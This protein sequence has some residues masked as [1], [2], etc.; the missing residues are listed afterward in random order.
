M[1]NVHRRNEAI[2]K[3][4]TAAILD[5]YQRRKDKTVSLR[6]ITQEKT[7]GEIADIDRLVDTFGI[8][9]FRG[10]ERLNQDEVDELDAVELDLYDEPKSQ[11]QRLRNVLYK[12]WQQN[13]EGDFKQF[14]RHETERIIQH[15]KNKLDL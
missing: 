7:S 1:G 8:V 15:Y 5:G 10:Q 11:S 3:I 6:F 12:V 2:L 9:Y 14:Y 4:L 13:Q